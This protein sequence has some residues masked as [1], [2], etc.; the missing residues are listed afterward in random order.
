[1]APERLP[2]DGG[3]GARA[4]KRDG[5]DGVGAKARLVRRAVELDE[6]PVD[7]GEV[8]VSAADGRGDLGVHGLDRAEHAAPAAEPLGSPSRRSTA[9]CR[10]VE[11]PEGTLARVVVP[12][13]SR[14]SASTVGRPRESR[15]S[16]VC[17]ETIVGLTARAGGRGSW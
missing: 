4:G 6:G 5:E 15:I 12:S 10:P 7:R 16:R 11:A 13:E 3:L 8:G 2:S 14:S 1:M 9:S 17:A